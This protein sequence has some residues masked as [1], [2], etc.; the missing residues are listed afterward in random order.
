MNPLF[1][2]K[3]NINEV[4]DLTFR[5][6]KKN[7]SALISLML[8]L[9]VP[10]YLV[11]AWVTGV[12]AASPI[13][14][15]LENSMDFS[16][17]DSMN[18]ETMN[19]TNLLTTFFSPQVMGLL[20]VLMILYFISIP[21]SK[22]AIILAVDQ[23]R[24]EETPKAIP[25]IKK[26]FTRFWPLQGGSFV[27]GLIYIGLSMGIGLIFVLFTV[28]MGII[29]GFES[30]SSIVLSI[31]GYVIIGI[32]SL[33]LLIYLMVRWGFYFPAIIFEKVSPG[34]S[35]SW[36]LTKRKF[37]FLLG[38]MLVIFIIMAIVSM[39]FQSLF[40]YVFDG[41]VIGILLTDLVSIFTT[42]F[43]YISF[44]IIYFDLLYRNKGEESNNLNQMGE[45]L[46]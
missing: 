36:T 37:W 41:N 40:S 17:F 39:I 45:D 31:I 3:L 23:V 43:F 5:V 38:R 11:Q 2:K 10:I 32:V 14:K 8:I 33:F 9:M 21:I 6:M 34:L 46:I 13:I 28:L 19:P 26:A 30:T 25:L 20:L 24:K 27:V 42:L 35:K 44:A 16:Q 1:E 15:K 4:L 12:I 29:G 22:A 7:F 18:P